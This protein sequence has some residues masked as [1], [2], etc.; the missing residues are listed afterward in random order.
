MGV[1]QAGVL[2]FVGQAIGAKVPFAMET[3]FSY[4]D[5]Q[6]NGSVRS[7]IDLIRE[8]QAKGYFVLLFFVG[9]ESSDLSILRV[10]TRVSEGGHSIDAATLVRR[11]PRTQMA[12]SQ[13]LNV[14]DAA[15]LTDNSRTSSE[16]FTVCRVQMG[17]LEL[18]DLRVIAKPTPSVILAWLNRVAP[19]P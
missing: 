13:A 6:P 10:D 8:M 7:K 19:R 1:A 9:L 17:P 18:Y 12:I 16:A 3:V 15:I 4:W 11:F 2:A 5:P 14:A